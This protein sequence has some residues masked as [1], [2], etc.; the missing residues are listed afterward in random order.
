MKKYLSLIAC[1]LLGITLFTACN[2][3][4]D[5]PNIPQEVLV[6]DGAFIINEG[7][8]Y[9]HINGTLDFLNYSTGTVS[10]NVFEA[11]NGRSL[12]GTPNNG[13][14][15]DSLLYIACTDENRVEV[16]STNTM[17]SLSS[18][19][20]ES[21]REMTYD[22]SYI[23]VTSYSGRVSA[24]SPSSN[25]VSATSEVIGDRLE[26]ITALGNY[27]YVANSCDAS[28]NYKTNVIQVTK[29]TLRVASDITVEKNPTQ[30]INDGTY[31]YVVCQGDYAT[32]QPCV[33][34]INL[35]NM[36]VE[37]IL[38]ATMIAFN[39]Q[40]S[41]YY[42]NYPYGSTP[43]YGVYDLSTRQAHQFTFSDQPQFP[44]AIAVDPISTDVFLTAL[45]PNPDYPQYASY[46]TNARLIRYDAQMT[47]KGEYEVGVN[48]GTIIFTAHTEIVN[49]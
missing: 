38:D 19:T 12:G 31:I 10:D 29:G 14:I 2:D 25:T 6:S 18:I 13:I 30:I 27:L 35:D 4:D 5:Y 15:V 26:G 48:P 23:Y 28:Y 24:I 34:R 46:T 39:G 45:N 9:S 44:Y 41:I 33:E 49:N 40:T 3:D 36:S 17:R 22:G 21:P 7:S 42:V 20:V 1:L 8:Y 11:V 43:T 37:K 47:K 16:V 32:V